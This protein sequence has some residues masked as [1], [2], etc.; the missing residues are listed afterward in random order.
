MRREAACDVTSFFISQRNEAK[1]SYQGSYFST[2]GRPA[3]TVTHKYDTTTGEAQGTFNDREVEID[4]WESAQTDV[5]RKEAWN[6]DVMSGTV[7]ARDLPVKPA[8]VFIPR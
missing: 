1:R 6:G 7:A 8:A 5:K 4:G 3:S 2:C